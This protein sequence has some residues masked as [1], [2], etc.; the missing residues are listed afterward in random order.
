VIVHK[1]RSTGLVAS[2]GRFGKFRK[3]R[4]CGSSK[5]WRRVWIPTAV[6]A[7]LLASACTAGSLGSRASQT[8]AKDLKVAAKNTAV[9][10]ASLFDVQYPAWTKGVL[11]AKPCSG[12]SHFC[13]VQMTTTPNGKILALADVS[14][15]TRVF[16]AVSRQRLLYEPAVI[17]G[18]ATVGRVGVWLSPDGR[19]VARG[20]SILN[21]KGE[22]KTIAFQ[23]WDTSNGRP[24]LT[25]GPT[26][27]SAW[28]PIE[29]VGL[30]SHKTLV[31]VVQ[32]YPGMTSWYV[33]GLTGKGYKVVAVH[34][35]WRDPVSITYLSDQDNWLLDLGDSYATWAP[36]NKPSLTI[37][38]CNSGLPVSKLNIRRKLYVCAAGGSRLNGGD[39]ALFWDI[40]RKLPSTT[41]IDRQR[42]GH[43]KDLTVLDNGQ[44]LA[45]LASPPSEKETTISGS[46]TLLLYS[47][48]PHP[49][50]DRT[51][52]LPDVSAGWS[53][54]QIGHFVV[55]FGDTTTGG[56]CCFAAYPWSTQK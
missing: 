51:I 45:I 29:A 26:R 42:L 6:L 37:V 11:A 56:F 30:H 16:N 40:T 48:Y 50:E 47:L 20:I 55:A 32:D 4:T 39:S 28:P 41:L 27:A 35:T 52:S 15:Q 25:D 5:C 49:S 53:I 17:T 8:R 14:G 34:R 2:T 38:P 54:Q 3:F 33:L 19:L 21:N 9:W 10:L 1:A 31:I 7:V 24:L 44:A 36:P 12:R 46:T 23:I 13:P 43:V 18:S 22:E